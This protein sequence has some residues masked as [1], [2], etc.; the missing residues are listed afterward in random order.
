MK[1]TDAD[2]IVDVGANSGLFTL[3]IASRNPNV[4]VI[5]FE[6]IPELCSVLENAIELANLKNVIVVNK[7]LGLDEG[8]TTMNV[9]NHDD[10]GI[11]SLMNLDFENIEANPYWQTRTDLYFDDRLRV[12][13]ARLDN[14]LNRLGFERVLFLKIDAQGCDLEILESGSA[15]EILSGMLELPS[16]KRNALYQGEPSMQEAFPKLTQMGYE[17]TG[18]RANDPASAEFNVTFT[19]GLDMEQIESDLQLMDIEIYS[20][21]GDPG[22]TKLSF[23]SLLEESRILTIKRLSEESIAQA[24]ALA[25]ERE[26]LIDL[27]VELQKNDECTE[28]LLLELAGT[29]TTLAAIR[30]SQSWR[31]MRPLRSLSDFGKKLFWR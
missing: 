30:N 22:A 20:K 15:V 29:K 28:K 6:P 16:A 9:S 19:S 21:N 24:N 11:S 8:V 18:I 23:S 10:R 14:E 17:V 27:K 13:V 7:A 26:L 25:K 1:L 12:E 2:C 5:A 4:K 31:L 3:E